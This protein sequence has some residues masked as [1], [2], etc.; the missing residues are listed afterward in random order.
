M[1]ETAHVPVSI[2]S[3]Q[4]LATVIREFPQIILCNVLYRAL[5]MK[6]TQLQN[7]KYACRLNSN[8]ILAIYVFN[9]VKTIILLI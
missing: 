1:K 8:I 4:N 2:L 3:L 5:V 9:F 6:F 7:G